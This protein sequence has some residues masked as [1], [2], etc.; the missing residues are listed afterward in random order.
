MNNYV[1]GMTLEQTEAIN[2]ESPL[3]IVRAG[4]GTGKTRVLINRA[5]RLNSLGRNVLMTT[6]TRA[7]RKEIEER[8]ASFTEDEF[9]GG[10]SVHT[11]NALAWRLAGCPV[12]TS[13]S[14]NFVL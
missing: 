6:F 3:I 10:T 11:L 7:S 9:S 1:E 2:G 4:A 12:L 13:Y 5:R 14:E 8:L